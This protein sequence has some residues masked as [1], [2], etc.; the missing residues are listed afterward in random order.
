MRAWAVLFDEFLRDRGIAEPYTD[1]DYFAHVDGKPRYVGV[2]DFLASRR[3]ELPEGSPQDGNDVSSVAGMGNRKN[4]VFTDIL[5]TDGVQA[6][7][8]S[9]RLLEALAVAGTAVAVVSSSRNARAVLEAA[10]IVERFGVVVDG[11][12]AAERGLSGKPAPD[13][14]WDAARQLGAAVERSVVVEDAVSG[15]AAGRAGGFGLVVGVD[16]GA[17]AG[18]LVDAGADV[19]VSDLTELVP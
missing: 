6:Y 11:I 14:F 19:V 10:G 1:A 18:A 13:T 7:P 17:G 2:R 9:V 3:I 12:N 4:A 16:R 8:G 15:V 5:R